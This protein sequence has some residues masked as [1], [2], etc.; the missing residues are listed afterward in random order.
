MKLPK[1]VDAE[2]ME[3]LSDVIKEH[4]EAFKGLVDMTLD[5]IYL[6]TNQIIAINAIQKKFIPLLNKSE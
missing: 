6:S 3:M 4:D 5:I 2:F 1:G